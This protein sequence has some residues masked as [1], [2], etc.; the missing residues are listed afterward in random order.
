MTRPAQDRLRT[1][2][3]DWQTPDALAA[4]VIAR[5]LRTTPQVRSVIEPTCGVGAFLV[6]AAAAFPEAVLVGL[7]REP[8]YVACARERLGE[9]A[10]IELGSF[11]DHDWHAQ[12]ARLPEP[13]LILGNPPWVT[14]S[15]TGALHASER[16]GDTTDEGPARR[17]RPGRSGL[18]AL[19]GEGNFD[20]S[21]WMIVA[22]LEAARG[23]SFTLSMLCKRSV[24]RRVL[25]HVAGARLPL[26]GEICR[27][28]ARAAFDVAVDAVLLTLTAFD[29]TRGAPAEPR[30]PV[31]DGLGA[32]APCG[33]IGVV[34]GCAVN[35]PDGYARTRAL[36][37]SAGEVSW[38]SGLKHD[39]APIMELSRAGGALRNGLGED[40]DI[41]APFLFPLLKGTD[42][43]RGRL[44]PTRA[45]LVPQRRLNEDT[46]RLAEEAPATWNY[47]ER[48]R[49]RFEQRKSRV[50]E[51]K[52]P[53]SIFG[54]GEY[55]F[56]PYKVAVSGLHKRLGFELVEPHEGRPVMFDDTCYFLPCAS[57]DDAARALD[58]LRSEA[59]TA[60]FEA[61][62]FWDAKRPINKRLLGSLSLAKLLSA[63]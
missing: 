38:R 15:T 51:G 49:A 47:L 57:R 22:L 31:F 19:T 54:V 2:R 16:S 9:R 55:A 24:A 45:V 44:S 30:W 7:D 37:A 58:A 62:V 32:D 23:R 17:S 26:A 11:Y 25:E 34:G 21:E 1:L 4:A 6:A 40:V 14:R 3:G 56:A 13:L 39:C 35:D 18:D 43:A 42:L 27:V 50:Y 41:E 53:F 12:L 52:P 48:H 20:V 46:R 61:R 63:G 10:K 5:L 60:F 36:E 59:A 29:P 28:D 33:A 8:S